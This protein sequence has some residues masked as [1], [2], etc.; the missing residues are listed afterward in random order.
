MEI[1]KTKFGLWKNLEV[2]VTFTKVYFL[3]FVK[4]FKEKKVQAKN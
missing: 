1:D 4:Y 3:K 2:F